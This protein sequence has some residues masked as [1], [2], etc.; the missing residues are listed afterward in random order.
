VLAEKRVDDLI[1]APAGGNDD[2]IK[3]MIADGLPVVSVDREFVGVEAGAIVVEN[4]SPRRLSCAI[5]SHW[6][7][8]AL[9]FYARVSA[10]IRSTIA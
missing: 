5:S 6:R 2:A 9:R 10:P 3:D 8:A 4:Y 1:I 7:I